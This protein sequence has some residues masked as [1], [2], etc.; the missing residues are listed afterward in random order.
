MR[1]IKKNPFEPQLLTMNVRNKPRFIVF[2][3]SRLRVSFLTKKI[4]FFFKSSNHSF[5]SNYAFAIFTLYEFWRYFFCY[6]CWCGCYPPTHFC[7]QA[8]PNKSQFKIRAS[9][10]TSSI[11]VDLGKAPAVMIEVTLQHDRS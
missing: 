2:T 6:I 10:K 8:G 9:A 1:V 5:W 7:F 4:W 11:K 3:V